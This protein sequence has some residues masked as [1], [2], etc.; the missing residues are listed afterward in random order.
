MIPKL[1]VMSVQRPLMTQGRLQQK[2]ETRC[3]GIIPINQ[4]ASGNRMHINNL[5]SGLIVIKF[6]DLKKN[7]CYLF[8]HHNSSGRQAQC[9]YLKNTNINDKT[10]GLEKL[11]RR[12]IWRLPEG[13]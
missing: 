2:V 6:V 5:L 8:D 13:S 10:K 12:G 11:E 7:S 9:Y 3:I 1:M 4:N